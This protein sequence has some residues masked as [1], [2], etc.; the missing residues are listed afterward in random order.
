[1]GQHAST[2]SCAR[3]SA[4]VTNLSLLILCPS[5]PC[6][7]ELMP[8][9]SDVERALLQLYDNLSSPTTSSLPQEERQVSSHSRTIQ[10][11]VSRPLILQPPYS[12]LY[13]PPAVCVL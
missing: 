4:C 2:L 11:P 8:S 7:A 9:M 3:L 5:L 13:W 10:Q 1:V 12:L 6:L